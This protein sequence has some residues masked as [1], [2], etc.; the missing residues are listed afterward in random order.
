MKRRMSWKSVVLVLAGVAVAAVGGCASYETHCPMRTGG[1]IAR[2]HGKPTCGYY[3]NWDDKAA[4]L[5]VAP[6][7]DT[8]PV[9]TQHVLVATVKDAAGNPLPSRRV[10]WL[11]TEG[12]VGAI[13]E[14]DESGWYDTRG[15]KVDNKYAVSHTNR[16]A[17]V[18]TRGNEDP[19]DDI[20]L[21]PGQTWCVITSAVEGDTHVVAYA[22]AIYDWDKHK[23]FAV[24]HWQD[25]GW[26]WPPDATNP[27]GTSHDLVVKVMKHSDQTPLADMVVNFEITDGPDAVLVPGNKKTASAK[28]DAKGMA[29]VTLKQA[30]PVEGAN[31]VAMEIIRPED[32]AYG[33][34]AM[35]LASGTMIKTWVGP[36]IAIEKTGPARAMV[37]ETIKYRIVVRNPG[38]APSTNVVVTDTIPDRLAYEASDPKGAVQGQTVTWKLGTM[39]PGA[40]STL[41]LH[42]KAGRT[43]TF[44]NCADVTADHGLKGRS[45]AT[46]VITA[47]KLTLEKSGPAEVLDCEPITYT[48]VVRNT[49]DGPATGVKIVDQLPD[50]LQTTDGNGAIQVNVGELGPGQAKKATYKVRATA[51]GTYTNTAV[52][53]GD[54][55]LKAEASSK[56]SVRRVALV[57]VKKGPAKRYINTAA[58]YEITVT[59]KGDGTARNLRLVDDLPAGLEFQRASD[60]GNLEG[61][62][63]TWDLGTLVPNASKTVSVDVVVRSMGTLRNTVTATAVCS[64]ATADTTTE[65]SGIAAIL[66]EVV[67]LE[68]P[69]EI[70]ANETYV[71]TVTNQ[72]SAVGTDITITCTLPAEAD[73]VS[74]KGP[75]QARIQGKKVNFAPLA[76][77]APKAKA[78]YHVVVKGNKAGDVRFAVDLNSDQMTGPASETESTHI[79]E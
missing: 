7:E 8:N 33:R 57:I 35:K 16:D 6:A 18:L 31:V 38:Q 42:V 68:D 15:Y 75:T 78:V 64:K 32:K 47:P 19:D 2:E 30:K 50:G 53:T 37:G 43:G 21:D 71:I 55:G 54:G 77:L 34:P 61:R 5:E 56:V 1:H 48:V 25:A 72:G 66:L 20:H 70:G 58:T 9:R 24:K 49:G 62:R 44:E 17:H 4:T 79:Y 27:I 65:V 46:T 29:K 22:P 40:A 67:D 52:A 73:Y 11:L 28:T 13:V 41:H 45:C 74:S 14:V 26:V 69:I 60:G 36:K 23:V 39:A 63:L 12:S 76:E 3:E 59:N 51:P 10:E